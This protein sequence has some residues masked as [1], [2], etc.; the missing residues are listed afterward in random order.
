MAGILA[1][2]SSHWAVLLLGISELL[3]NI[4]GVKSNSIFQLLVSGLQ[5]ISAPAPKP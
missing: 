2:L 5:A 3:A 1:F 4:P